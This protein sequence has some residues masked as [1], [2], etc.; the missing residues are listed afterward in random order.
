MYSSKLLTPITSVSESF[1]DV[2][3]ER[4]FQQLDTSNMKHSFF[5]LSKIVS[6]LPPPQKKSPPPRSSCTHTLTHTHTH[7]RNGV[8]LGKDQ[9]FLRWR[10]KRGEGQGRE[11]EEEEHLS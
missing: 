3:T 7:A 10:K 1:T 2:L 6:Q 8:R 11:W 9:V 5:S 4:Y